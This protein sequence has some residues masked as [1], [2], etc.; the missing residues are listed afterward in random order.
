MLKAC[1]FDMDGVI[2]DSEPFHM[3]FEQE[4]FKSLS[5]EVGEEEH[6]KFVG[7]TSHYM[8]EL[9]RGKYNLPFSLEEL[10][11]KDRDN[12]YDFLVSKCD[13]KPIEGVK[14]LIRNL[15]NSGFKL[16]I[17]SS[18]PMDV[19]QVVTEKLDINKYFNILVTGD[20]VKKSKPEPDIFLYAAEKLGVRF[21][22]CIVIEDSHN[23]ILAAKNAGMKCIGFINKNS[24]NQ[25]LT[26][27]DIIIKKFSDLKPKVFGVHE[28]A[29]P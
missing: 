15:Y 2:L 1:I 11:K 29:W 8:W 22:E 18:S 16:A 5:I 27:A 24:G 14:D 28:K 6:M 12:Y 20:Y 26:S 4:L 9:I 7:T 23:G 21:N 13:I 3:K 17:A 10:V 19:I 25:D